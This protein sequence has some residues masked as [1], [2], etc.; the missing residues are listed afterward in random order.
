MANVGTISNIGQLYTFTRSGIVEAGEKWSDTEVWGR[1]SWVS[2]STSE[3]LRLFVREDDRGEF[4]V[5][6]SNVGFG[7]REGHR[8][9]IVFAGDQASRAG[10]PAAL[11]N[12]STGNSKIFDPQIAR[13]V[14]RLGQDAGCV[15]FIG[16]G[17]AGLVIGNVFGMILYNLSG[18]TAW[19]GA[20]SLGFLFGLIAAPVFP[21]VIM[22]RGKGRKD[23]LTKAVTQ[24]VGQIVQN[25]IQ[26]EKEGVR[27]S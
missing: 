26:A 13:L 25:S 19:R 11:I 16:L 2:S 1:D 18:G 22:L 5:K 7:V 4:D 10:Y 17:F 3:N 15:T 24:Q 23:R 14:P 27:A 12:H 20:E 8:V 6:L 21:T 9:T